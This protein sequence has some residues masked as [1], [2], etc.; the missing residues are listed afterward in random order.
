[1]EVLLLAVIGLPVGLVLDALVARLAVRVDSHAEAED[2][3]VPAPEPGLGHSEAGS[4]V[5]EAAPAQHVWLRRLL[6][7]SATILL[8][9]LAG[10]QYGDVAHLPIVTAY[11]SVLI[12]CA[13][14]DMLSFRVPNVVTYPAI[15]A[16][17]AI[18][19]AMPDANALEVL[20]GGLLAGGV[21]LLPSLLTGGIGMGMGDVKL[22]TFVG[23]SLGFTNVV[24]AMLVMALL[25]GA[26]AVFLLLTGLR[27]RGEPIPYAPFIS[28]GGIVALLSQGSA[29]ALV[30]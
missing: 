25:G 29:F 19:I 7:T 15:V 21:L 8:F 17:L 10:A 13:G 30:G 26:V 6:I 14:T 28:A 24:P 1:M 23:L 9:A 4:L 16:A 18:G 12:V 27:K 2:E 20:A 5:L 22:A 3:D 11:L